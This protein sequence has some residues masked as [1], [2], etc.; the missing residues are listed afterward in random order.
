MIQATT[1]G[2]AEATSQRRHPSIRTFSYHRMGSNHPRG[3]QSARTFTCRLGGNEHAYIGAETE[4]ISASLVK[5]FYKFECA[6]ACGN[7]P[8][9]T[10]PAS[11]AHDGESRCAAS[12]AGATRQACTR[13]RSSAH[14]DPT[15]TR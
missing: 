7:S 11:A 9:R 8:G 15:E 10:H 14:R 5:Q 3:V 6:S 13:I 4:T 2:R 12:A 1:A